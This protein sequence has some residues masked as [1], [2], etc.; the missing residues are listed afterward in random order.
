MTESAGEGAAVPET[1][2]Q[3]PST[4][5]HDWGWVDRSIWTERM[6]AALENGVQ[7]GKW[8]SLIDKVYR[9]QTLAAAWEQVRANRGAAGLDGQ[10]VERFAAQAE[11]YLGELAEELRTERYRA[12]PVRRVEIA[13]AD[14]KTRPLGIPTVKDRI[15]QAAV[16]RVIEP[17]FE[18]EFLPTSYG[19]RPGRGCKDALRE[20]DRLLRAGFTHVVDADLKSYFDSI[21]RDR[22]QARIEERISD[23]RLLALLTQWLSQ[24][25]VQGLRRW[26]PTQGTPQ[27]AIISPLLA[28]LYL[29]PL[30]VVM[31][32][33]GYPL[34]RYADDFVILCAS[35]AEAQA[36][37]AEVQ[38]WVEAN[39]LSL[40]PD[41]THVGDC[42]VVGQGFE[43]LGYRFE[44]GRRWVRKK[45]LRAL[46]DKVRALTARTRGD[47]LA[48]IMAELNPVL[49]GWFH[50]FQHAG[51]TEF[52][53]LDGFVRRRLRAV[54]RKQS[55]HPGFGRCVA[56]H[57]R[58][59][60]AYF[61][62]A[63]LFTLTTAWQRAS[64]SR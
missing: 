4:R 63:G 64:Q 3:A 10:S 22:L 17:I 1:A 52:P 42:R 34:V 61:A 47:S 14:G 7:G 13:K 57:R 60:N 33:R 19:F 38:A 30:D 2:K 18:R 45:S 37:L 15:V 46:K 5:A 29:H 51:R 53:T 55:K 40:H 36:A 12:A 56:D 26:T 31:A 35:A 54:L 6:L 28:N 44:A 20:V 58:W 8:F 23:G 50:Y 25:V 27:G 24:D 49:R 62:A 9:P 21:P 39:G 11:R 32:Q 43:F 41:K 16:K 48:R 59:P